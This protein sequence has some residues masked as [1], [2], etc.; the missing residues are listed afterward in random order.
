MAFGPEARIA[1]MKWEDVRFAAGDAECAGRL[2]WPEEAHGRVPCVV[3]GT[4]ISCVRDQGLDAFAERLA[5]A[6][7][8]ALAFDYRHWGESGGAPRS[9][10]DSGR[11]R[12]D[13]RAAV[14]YARGL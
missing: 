4:G 7:F 5:D 14:S 12:E 10:V 11:Q 13:L 1:T 6:G 8:A 9:L 2:F 3:M